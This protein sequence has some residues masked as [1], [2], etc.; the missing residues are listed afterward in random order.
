MNENVNGNNKYVNSNENR[1][2]GDDFFD[3]PRAM[4]ASRMQG[5]SWLGARFWIL[6][7]SIRFRMVR[8]CDDPIVQEK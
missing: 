2:A 8:G 6:Q 1:F 7:E 4:A 5:Q 3:L